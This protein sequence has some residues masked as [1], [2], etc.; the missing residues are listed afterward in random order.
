MSDGAMHCS[1]KVTHV[2]VFMLLVSQVIFLLSE[3]SNDV[4]WNPGDGKRQVIYF[5]EWG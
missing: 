3:I 5:A 2:Q 4:Q 1:V